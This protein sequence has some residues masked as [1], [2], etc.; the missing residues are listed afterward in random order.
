MINALVRNSG[1]RYILPIDWVGI[2]YY[3]IGLG[4]LTLWVV[5]YFRES[6]LPPRV[7]G[8]ITSQIM[9]MRQPYG[10]EPTWQSQH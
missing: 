6:E 3:S 9:I 8:K 1:G 4:Q 7:V 2:F 5:A 10:A